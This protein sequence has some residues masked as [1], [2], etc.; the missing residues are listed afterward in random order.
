MSYSNN[1]T[2]LVVICAVVLAVLGII[3]F[4]V[5]QYS[6]GAWYTWI[7]AFLALMVLHKF[8][9]I[10]FPGLMHRLAQSSDGYYHDDDDDYFHD[11]YEDRHSWGES[12]DDMS[13]D[14]DDD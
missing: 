13:D 11:D 12:D 6:N 5:Y 4:S 8:L 10:L 2:G 1:Q 7:P 3:T 9:S 14:A